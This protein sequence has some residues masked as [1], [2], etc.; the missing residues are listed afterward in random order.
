MTKPFVHVLLAALANGPVIV[1]AGVLKV[2]DTPVLFVS[3]IFVV[4][5]VRPTAVVANEMVVGLSET[6]LVPVPLKPISCGVDGSVSLMT[7][8]ARFKPVD[9]GLNVT[10]IVQLAPPASV[11]PDA[12]HVL[13]VIV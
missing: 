13:V 3:V 9:F 12:G 6:L 5:L 4:L 1:M 10:L 8:D 2:M 11:V 7:T